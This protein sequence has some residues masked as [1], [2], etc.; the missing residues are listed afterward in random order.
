MSILLLAPYVPL[1]FMGEEYGKENPFP[2]FCSFSSP[3]LV[4]AVREGRRAEFAGFEWQGEVP[5]P[6]DE[7]TF[8]SA[9]LSWRWDDPRRACLHRLYRDLL[10]ARSRWPARKDFESRHARIVGDVLE[11]RCGGDGVVAHFNLTGRPLP[12]PAVPEGRKVLFRSESPRYGGPG[13]MPLAA[14]ECVVHEPNAWPA[15]SEFSQS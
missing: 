12:L 5:D 13:G 1:V 10:A 15:T 6:Q 4:L 3:D 7:G 11:Y 2:F 8:R 9:V 14:L